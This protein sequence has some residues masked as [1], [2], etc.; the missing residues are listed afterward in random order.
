MRSYGIVLTMLAAGCLESPPTSNDAG[1][2]DADGGVPLCGTTRALREEFDTLALDPLW[3][4]WGTASG[5]IGG[6]RRLIYAAPGQSGGINTTWM[7]N[8][9]GGELVL[10]LRTIGLGDGGQFYLQL[11]DADDDAV[12]LVLEGTTLSLQVYLDG[13]M[14]SPDSTGWEE[15]MLWWRLVEEDG[16]ILWGVSSDGEHWEDHEP[17]ENPL[18]DLATLV[19]GLTSDTVQSAVEIEGINPDSTELECPAASLVDEFDGLSPRWTITETPDCQVTSENDLR[20]VYAGGEY[21]GIFSR[22]HFDLTGSQ[23]AIDVVDA[24]DC[25]TAVGFAV[26]LGDWTAEMECYDD[27]GQP[28]LRAGLYGDG[29]PG[30]VADVDYLPT[31]HRLWRIAEEGGELSWS[32]ADAGGEWSQLG[33]TPIAADEV[34]AA[35][36]SILVRDESPDGLM[37]EVILDR[38]NLV[39]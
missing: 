6:G 11:L 12:G 24:R 1:P 10:A 2:I 34:T 27:A 38:L 32:A 19:F 15:D 36:L 35:G 14:T 18:S 8:V 3:E 23:M 39:P 20:M 13:S 29:A 5:D 4:G 22:E 30:Q 9:V 17:I 16:K 26:D 7:F 25:E 37:D 31:L 28:R 33:S 21:C